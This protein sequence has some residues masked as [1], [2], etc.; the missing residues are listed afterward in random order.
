V[1]AIVAGW[2]LAQEPRFLPGLTISQ[3]AAERST[4][5]AVVVGVAA[6]AVVHVP[7]LPVLFTLFLRGRLEAGVLPGLPALAVGG[8]Y[9]AARRRFR[10]TRSAELRQPGT[11]VGRPP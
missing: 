7:S 10:L 3:A 11:H 4:L 5:I 9:G 8:R 1:A 6:G 2:A